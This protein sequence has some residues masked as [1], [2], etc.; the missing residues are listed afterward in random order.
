M[1]WSAAI[2]WETKDSSLCYST[3]EGLYLKSEA[4]RDFNGDK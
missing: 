3:V 1:E 2:F 4:V